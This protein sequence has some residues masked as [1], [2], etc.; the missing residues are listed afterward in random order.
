MGYVMEP[1]ELRCQMRDAMTKCSD[2]FRVIDSLLDYLFLL[3]P[4][5]DYIIPALIRRDCELPVL[6]VFNLL[7]CLVSS[8]FLMSTLLLECEKCGYVDQSVTYAT[9]KDCPAWIDCP[10]CGFKNDGITETIIVYKF[11]TK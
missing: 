2:D 3:D 7:E 10:K 9:F 1:K 8:G 5:S 4:D 6:A 11:L